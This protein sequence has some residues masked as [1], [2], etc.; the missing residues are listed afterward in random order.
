MLEYCPREQALSKNSREIRRACEMKQAWDSAFLQ[1][2]AWSQATFRLDLFLAFSFSPL[3][4]EDPELFLFCPLCRPLG[5][6]SLFPSRD[7]S[8]FEITDSALEFL[9]LGDSPPV[10]LFGVLLYDFMTTR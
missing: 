9:S 5:F 6:Q 7:Q 2:Q 10:L 1:V 3:V 4:F 8:R